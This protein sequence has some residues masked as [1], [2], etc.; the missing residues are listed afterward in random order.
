MSDPFPYHRFGGK[1]SVRKE[2]SPIS[3]ALAIC[4]LIHLS[5]PSNHEPQSR[6]STIPY[7]SRFKCYFY[8]ERREFIKDLTKYYK[9]SIILKIM[10]SELFHSW[11][12][13]SGSKT[14]SECD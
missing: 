5:E 2:G 14:Q 11:L 7:G 9:N 13:E 10:V 4:L 3:Q 12:S 6:G 1:L 8:Y